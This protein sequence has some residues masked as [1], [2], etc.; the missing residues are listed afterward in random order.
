VAEEE[1]ASLGVIATLV[2]ALLHGGFGDFRPLS[3]P[4]FVFDAEPVVALG[5]GDDEDADGDGISG[6][7]GFKC[8][9]KGEA[10]DAGEVR[11]A[12]LLDG[13]GGVNRP[14]NRFTIPEGAVE[15]SLAV[16]VASG[17]DFL[18]FLP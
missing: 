1:D 7:E 4:P 8:T 16:A 15:G 17:E 12:G 2:A 14:A 3:Q 6:D 10:F 18:C 11:L 5:G 13:A 9:S